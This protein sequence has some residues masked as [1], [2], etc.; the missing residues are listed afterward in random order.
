[1]SL[2]EGMKERLDRLCLAGIRTEA[3]AYR[4]HFLLLQ[5]VGQYP[6]KTL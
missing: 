6:E 1:M 2:G 5:N 3:N 4:M